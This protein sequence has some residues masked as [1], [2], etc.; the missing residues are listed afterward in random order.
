M[1]FVFVPFSDVSTPRVRLIVPGVTKTGGQIGTGFYESRGLVFIT[2]QIFTF[3]FG[4]G[5]YF[6]FFLFRAVWD[7][8]VFFTLCFVHMV[9]ST[10]MQD[11]AFPQR[12]T[13]NVAGEFR[14]LLFFFCFA[15]VVACYCCHIGYW[16]SQGYIQCVQEWK[17][18][19]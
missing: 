6:P 10:L 19:E 13:E 17:P 11:G 5:F 18:V 1:F 14:P 3:H 7:A 2:F 8:H 4:E 15:A 16:W 9:G 12:T